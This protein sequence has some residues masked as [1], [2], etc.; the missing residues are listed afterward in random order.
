MR[1]KSNRSPKRNRTKSSGHQY[2]TLEPRQMLATLIGFEAATGQLEITLDAA[3]DTALISINGSGEVEVNGTRDMNSV[4][5]GVQAVDAQ[6]IQNMVIAGVNG[7]ANQQVGLGGSFVIPNTSLQNLTVTG[8]T[9]V[10]LTGNY[11]VASDLLIDMDGSGGQLTDQ[12]GSSL[13]VGGNTVISGGLNPVTL[14]VQVDFVGGVNAST[15]AGTDVTISDANDLLISRLDVGGD[16]NLTANGAI[17]DVD[18]TT[19]LVEGD[20]V[21]S[22]S[23]V[24]LGD[25]VSDETNFHRT[26]FQVPGHVELHEDSNIIFGT[27]TIGSLMAD[28]AG[29]IFDGRT[30]ELNIVGNA[31]LIGEA[32]IRLGEHGTDTFNAGSV[33][34]ETIGHA[35]LFEDSGTHFVGATTAR[36]MDVTSLGDVT[37]ADDATIQTTFATGFEGDN[38]VLG[39]SAT[40]SVS[41]GGV[42]FWSLGD[43]TINENADLFVIDSK[44]RANNLSLT[45]TGSIQDNTD[46]WITVDQLAS[47]DAVS[48]TLGEGLD[49]H[50][51]AGSVMFDVDQQFFIRE[52][53][54][55]NIA[56]TN[57]ANVANIG[58]AGDITNSPE[59]QIAVAGEARFRAANVDVGNQDSDQVNL[60]TLIVVTPGEGLVSED[61][62]TTITGE[63]SAN[64]LVVRSTGAIDNA[65]GSSINV[66]S[67]ASFQGTTGVNI[68]N[69]IDDVFNALSVIGNSPGAEVRLNQ[70]SSMFVAGVNRSSN[71]FLQSTGT[72][73]NAQG[74]QILVDNQLTVQATGLIRL[75]AQ[76]DG[77]TNQETDRIE[78]GSLNVNSTQN[79]T[80]ETQSDIVF[81]GSSTGDNL[82]IVARDG[83]T[84]FD[85][86]DQSDSSINVTSAMFLTGL[87]VVIGELETDCLE[88]GGAIDVT[89]SGTNN[90]VE[91]CP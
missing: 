74:A 27:S 15:L 35:H 52:D 24:T 14:T 39:D 78:L 26:S 59:S 16:A 8:V 86:S 21:F 61:S 4:Q 45:S 81:A 6:D 58:A 54:A 10:T 67:V 75:G 80:V 40:D 76:V 49:D 70:D 23:D 90:V 18:G 37:D 53:S 38:I 30:T 82:N 71:M 55:L 44:N 57:Q 73:G 5:S 33:T 28:S 91:G 69:A 7:V 3:N 2:N 50:F 1:S 12:A 85:I 77:E 20:G 62:S 56:G 32:S 25:H 89:A 65:D 13:R 34:L 41:L 84:D 51:N 68:G 79:V 66:T 31:H 87:D 47:F 60:G 48:V 64:R 43:V 88:V 63:T 9:E 19:I 29:G 83:N 22:A 42:Y 36:T 17:T 46:A 11:H 72:I